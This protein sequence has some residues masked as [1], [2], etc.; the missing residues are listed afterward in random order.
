MFKVCN[1]LNQ[2]WTAACSFTESAQGCPFHPYT[3]VEAEAVFSLFIEILHGF[4]HFMQNSSKNKKSKLHVI[5]A[6]HFGV[7]VFF[8]T[9][10]FRR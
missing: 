3:L 8:F 9:V 6:V 10:R 2:K 4:L 1:P 5:S 7:L